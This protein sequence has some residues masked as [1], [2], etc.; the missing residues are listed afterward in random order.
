MI[1]MGSKNRIAKYILPIILKGRKTEQWYVEP[2]AGGM[3][4][5]DKVDGKRLANDI[6]AELVSMWQALLYEGWIP[7]K[8]VSKCEYIDIRDNRD[9]YPACLVGWVGFNCSYS[10]KWFGGY[11]GKTATKNGHIRDYQGEAIRNVAKQKS[12]MNGVKISNENYWAVDIPKN[13]IIYCDPP[14]KGTTGYANSFD[15]DKFWQWCRDK[16]KEGHTVFIS[17]YSAPADFK[18]VWSMEVKSSLSANGTY[19]GSKSSTEKLFTL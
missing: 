9:N 15:S 8:E 14:Y 3:N 12:S 1:Y 10:G 2:F 18:C 17:E 5:I 6:H 4:T 13:S 16:H 19:G 11:A 7:P